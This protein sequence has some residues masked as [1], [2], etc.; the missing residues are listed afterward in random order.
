MWTLFIDILKKLFSKCLL[1]LK[2]VT[3]QVN[4]IQIIFLM[5]FDFAYV[6]YLFYLLFNVLDF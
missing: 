4:A 2:Y 1:F 3:C 6:K 5:I